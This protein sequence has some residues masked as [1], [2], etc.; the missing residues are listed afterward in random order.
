MSLLERVFD[1]PTGLCGKFGGWIM[2]QTNREIME[3]AIEE[4]DLQSDDRVLEVGCG[5]GVG[6]ELV[7]QIVQ[8]GLVAGVDPSPEMVEMA[9]RRNR[10][11]VRE[12]Q[13]ELTEA[14]VENLPYS[15]EQF[16]RIW[17]LDVMHV[18]EDPM[19]GLTQCRRVLKP[20]GVVLL[21]FSPHSGQ[22]GE[23]WVQCM[24]QAGFES[25]LF[26]RNDLGFLVIASIE[27]SNPPSGP[28]RDH[29]MEEP[30]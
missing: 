4:L 23:G 7:N 25:P 22:S 2:K 19:A 17:A 30:R 6:I 27:T 9:T 29:L 16:D 5:P 8:S 28:E 12:G 18:P 1:R 14:T 15:G 24:K 26:K 10:K 20:G 3:W 11:A 13:V 21:A